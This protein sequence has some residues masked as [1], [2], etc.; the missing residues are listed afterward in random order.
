MQYLEEAEQQAEASGG[1]PPPLQI[2]ISTHFVTFS[3]SLFSLSQSSFLDPLSSPF[4]HFP[5]H[6]FRSTLCPRKIKTSKF[7]SI[8]VLSEVPLACGSSAL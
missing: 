3:L 4:P 6:P 8:S 5:C 1:V 2:V 7:H